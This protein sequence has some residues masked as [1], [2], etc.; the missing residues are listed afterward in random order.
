[1][2]ILW[3]NA[4]VLPVA[5]KVLGI[6]PGVGGGWLQSTLSALQESDPGLQFCVLCLDSRRF[7]VEI[8]GVRHVS[9]G[10]GVYTYND[11]PRKIQE[12]AK[13]V[14]M[15]FNPDI[16]HVQGTEYFFGR[17]DDD[18]YCG[19]PVVVSIQGILN[20]CW[21]H[22]TGGIPWKDMFG[23]YCCN[24]RALIRGR[25]LAGDQNVWRAARA[26]QERLVFSRQ[27]YFIGRTEWDRHCLESFNPTAKYYHV[28]ENLR[29]PFYCAKRTQASV[30]R[31]TI[32][33]A[34]AA[35]YPL[36][37][38]HWLFRAIAILKDEFPD[39]QLRVAG[40]E[41]ILNG[42]T[43]LY[44]WI[45]EQAYYRYLRKLLVDLGIE[46]NVVGL[47]D[48]EAEQVAKELERAELYVS[49]SLCENS[50]NSLGEAMLVGTPIVQTFVGGVPSILKDGVEGKLVPPYDPY[51]LSGAIR[52]LF[53][54]PELG[55][56]CVTAA[57]GTA[58]RRH[59]W[60]KNAYAMLEVY[61]EISR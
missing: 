32:Y 44:A 27:H 31:H 40:A 34:G 17:M 59:D 6:E 7:D 53:R 18:V 13:R 36:K 46:N 55:E 52:D 48:L 33:S 25:T 4:G 16:I 19:K 45:H 15:D 57:R 23:S 60:H 54:N 20:E 38:A 42:P 10:T 21:I 56:T 43:N 14:I 30:R 1:M 41:R 50:P 22:L 8:Q 37:G 39:V 35:S 3:F 47:P 24:P 12:E 61:R 58:L 26:A 29:P 2:R 51:V 49:A 28:D 5:S 11:V 9:F